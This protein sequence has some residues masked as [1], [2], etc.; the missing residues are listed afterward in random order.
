MKRTIL[1]AA[2]FMFAIASAFTTKAFNVTGWAN[3]G[4]GNPVS[5]STNEAGCALNPTI[6]CSITVSG[7]TY[8]PVYDAQANIG[9]PNKIL[10]HN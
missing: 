5:A 1:I 9:D 4:L 2:I 3:N 10:K 6:N 7:V 8:N